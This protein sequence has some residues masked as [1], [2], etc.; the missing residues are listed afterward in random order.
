MEIMHKLKSQS[1]PTVII[2]S[3]L[4]QKHKQFPSLPKPQFFLLISIFAVL[5]EKF[6]NIWKNKQMEF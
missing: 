3:P 6:A 2:T 5:G 1:G 4:A